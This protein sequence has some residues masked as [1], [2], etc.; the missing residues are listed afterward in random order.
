M[1]TMMTPDCQPPTLAGY[2][3]IVNNREVRKAIETREGLDFVCPD[4]RARVI[5]LIVAASLVLRSGSRRKALAARYAEKPVPSLAP[6][7]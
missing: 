4:Q 6:P 5:D 7:L 2:C 3:Y 1:L